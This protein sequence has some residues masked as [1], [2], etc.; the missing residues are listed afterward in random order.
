[1]AAAHSLVMQTQRTQEDRARL[2]S[3]HRATSCHG[4]GVA[5]LCVL[6]GLSELACL[7]QVHSRPRDQRKAFGALILTSVP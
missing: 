4:R 5:G 2:H 7:L 3:A 1:M 6:L